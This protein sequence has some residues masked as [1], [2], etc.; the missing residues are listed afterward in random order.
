MKGPDFLKTP[1]AIK[2]EEAQ[3]LANMEI[4]LELNLIVIFLSPYRCAKTMSV[5]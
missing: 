4:H 5:T 3:K 2:E 1:N